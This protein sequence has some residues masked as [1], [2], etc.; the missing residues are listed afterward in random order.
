MMV[1]AIRKSDT[2]TDDNLVELSA[3]DADEILETDVEVKLKWFN[4]P[5]GFGFV[6]PNDKDVDAFL[7]ITTLQKA[8][9][10]NIG[11]GAVLICDIGYGSKGA[12]VRA[13]KAMLDAGLMP[14]E[15]SEELV[16]KSGFNGMEG[17]VKWYKPDKGFG[18][19]IP[20]DGKKDVFVHKTCLEKHDIDSL[21]PGQRIKMAVKDVPKGRE[22]V[23]IELTG[24][25]DTTVIN[26]N[27]ANSAE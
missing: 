19:V 11:E 16:Q 21:I 9:I 24:S 18:F 13:V 27:P 5:K 22:A 25:N 12:M 8:E 15:N 3:A 4:Q 14:G 6:V 1:I 2:K 7:H 20:D 23:T 10:Q 26:F 17:T